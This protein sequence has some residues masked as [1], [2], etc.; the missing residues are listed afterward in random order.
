[1]DPVLFDNE[2]RAVMKRLA[3]T[4]TPHRDDSRQ[5]QGTL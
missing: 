5:M 2:L 1:M 3:N 4:R